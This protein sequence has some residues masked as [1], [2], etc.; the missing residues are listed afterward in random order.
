MR[1]LR[2]EEGVVF[3]AAVSLLIP[4][5]RWRGV[6]LGSEADCRRRVLWVIW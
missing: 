5:M 1:G 3:F 6:C 4:G 2:A